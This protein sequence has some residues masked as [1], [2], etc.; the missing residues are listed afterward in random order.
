MGARARRPHD[1]PAGHRRYEIL[2]ELRSAGRVRAPAPT[3]AVAYS[4][5]FRH[6]FGLGADEGVVQCRQ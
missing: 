5:F 1:P 3:R 6:L 2:P 4:R